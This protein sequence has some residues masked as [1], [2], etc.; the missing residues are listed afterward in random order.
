MAVAVPGLVVLRDGGDGELARAGVVSAVV[1][2]VGAAMLR[3]LAAS[4]RSAYL[5]AG[6]SPNP[7]SPVLGVHG[8]YVAKA[9]SQGAAPTAFRESSR[10]EPSSVATRVR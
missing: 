4:T 10:P 2:I 7:F 3:M 5:D 9:P 1:V 8:P 6:L